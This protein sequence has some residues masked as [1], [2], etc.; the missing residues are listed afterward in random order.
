MTAD[1]PN[2]V[3]SGRALDGLELILSGILD[4]LD[5]YSLPTDR[6]SEA[7]L[8][9]E[10]CIATH[11]VPGQQL[12]IHDPDRTPLAV[13]HIERVRE[14]DAGTRWIEGPVSR[15]QP[16][17][18]GYAR[19]LRPT[20]HTDLTGCTVGLFSGLPEDSDLSAVRSAARGGPVALTYVGESDDRTTA[21]GIQLL[22]ASVEDSP[23]TRVLFVPEVDLG[24]HADVA[25]EVVNRLGAA[26]VIDRRRPVV[27]SE[28][29]VVL[30]TG[31]SGA[32]KSTL[33]RALV[34]YIH[35]FTTRSAVLLD[36][37]DVRRELAG[38]L[39][40]GPADRDRNLRR[41]AWVAARVAEVGGLAVCAPIAPFAAS[42]AAMRDAVEPRSPFIVVYVST[43]L[44]VAEERDRKGLYE[45]ARSGLITDFTGIGSPY[46]IPEDADLEL[47]TAESSVEDCVRGVVRL[48]EQRGV[49]KT[50][51]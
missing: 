47:N 42:R 7:G 22:T 46:E 40:F 26:D 4:S 6:N 9:A 28:G 27:T 12:V 44:D 8:T 33:A 48:L 5:G 29:A 31:L 30:F 2:V 23:D 13:C 1:S 49:L 43:P 3:L 14:A 38:E 24:G 11:V 20:V 36:G 17:E 16:P 35:A 50:F 32:G 21:A 41:I 39:G 45:K 15:L 51:V 37:D 18:H 25:A 10:L 19:R 34:E